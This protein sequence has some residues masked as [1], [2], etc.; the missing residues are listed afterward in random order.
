MPARALRDNSS[1]GAVITT[2]PTAT[3]QLGGRHRFVE[4]C[5]C[6]QHAENDVAWTSETHAPRNQAS[7]IQGSV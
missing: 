4:C 6:L 5:W 2:A 3:A 7:V 1:R